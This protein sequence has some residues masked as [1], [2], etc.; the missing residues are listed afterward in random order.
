MPHPPTHHKSDLAAFTQTRPRQTMQ[1]RSS[2]A[3]SAATNRASRSCSSSRNVASLRVRAVAAPAAAAQQ[4]QKMAGK[5]ITFM[6][7]QGLGND[8]IL[9]RKRVDMVVCLWCKAGPSNSS[10][11]LPARR[12]GGC[13][14]AAYWS[15]R[16]RPAHEPGSL[17]FQQLL[18]H[19]V[20][21]SS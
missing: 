20:C 21:S 18:L 9:V 1:L 2:F 19:M 4:Q 13:V 14:C 11:E 15:W 12:T 7:Y 5:S 16:P 6:K 10:S 17:R 8:F 3:A